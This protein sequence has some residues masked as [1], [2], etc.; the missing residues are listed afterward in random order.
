[1]AGAATSARRQ[2]RERALGLL[3]EASSKELPARQVVAEL[4]VAPDAYATTLAIGVDEHR[5][6]IDDVVTRHLKGSWRLERLPVV[7]LTVL[8]LAIYELAH[9][10]DVPVAVAISEAVELA[11]Q[12]STDES[13][14]FVNGV[15]REAAAELRPK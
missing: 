15:L 13:G 2:A 14:R 4:P 6:Q 3:Y 11:K 8:R 7:D 1:M 10:P 5:T 12:F 9:E